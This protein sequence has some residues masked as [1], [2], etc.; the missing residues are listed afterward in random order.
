MLDTDVRSDPELE[1]EDDP[2]RFNRRRVVR[3]VTILTLG[4]L[5]VLAIWQ[6]PLYADF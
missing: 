4:I 6:D 5:A 1:P 3:V 2:G